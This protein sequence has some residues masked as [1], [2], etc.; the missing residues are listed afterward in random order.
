MIYRVSPNATYKLRGEVEYIMISPNY[1]GKHGRKAVGDSV[2]E[3]ARSHHHGFLISDHGQSAMNMNFYNTELAD[4]HFIYGLANGKGACRCSV[5]WKN[6]SNKAVTET[7]KARSG[8]SEPDG[9]WNF[10]SHN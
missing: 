1:I 9:T 3:L 7:L 8:A 2:R 4:I 5:V 10:Q 6:I